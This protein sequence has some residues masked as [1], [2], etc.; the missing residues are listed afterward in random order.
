[1]HSIILMHDYDQGMHMSIWNEKVYE[2]MSSQNDYEFKLLGLEKVNLVK[3]GRVNLASLKLSQESKPARNRF[4]WVLEKVN[5][6]ITYK[7]EL[8]Y[9]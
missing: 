4:V 9:D 1:M 5:P 8:G 6:A 7:D 3:S 2:Y